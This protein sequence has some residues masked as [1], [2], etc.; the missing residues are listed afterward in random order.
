[1]YPVAEPELQSRKPV[2]FSS[3][4]VTCPV[5]LIET[6]E[7]PSSVCSATD[8]SV[9][10]VGSSA[11]TVVGSRLTIMHSVNSHANTFLF[12]EIPPFYLKLLKQFYDMVNS[13]KR[14]FR[15]RTS[16]S[17]GFVPGMT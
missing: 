1:M 17:S 6:S 15:S 9:A 7:E 2:T 11:R 16:S 10:V 3:V 14:A 8:F 12:I 5:P 4:T 13:R